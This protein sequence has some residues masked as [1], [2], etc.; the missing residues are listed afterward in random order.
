M[1]APAWVSAT[2]QSSGTATTAP[3]VTLPTTAANDVLILVR[4]NGGGTAL[5]APGGTYNG[6]AWASIDSGTW[7]T[8]AG[9]CMWSRCTGNHS[10]QTVTA[11]TVDSGS[12][13]VI[14]VSGCITTGTPLDVNKSGATVAAGA[15]GTLV[16]FNTTAVDTLVCLTVAVDDN[17]ALTNFTKNAVAMGNLSTSASSG[18]ADSGNGWAGSAQASPGATGD[19]A[20]SINAGTNEG[21][22]ASGFALLSVRSVLLDAGTAVSST[23]VALTA[24][25]ITALNAGT[26]VSSTTV[27]LTADAQITAEATGVSSA[28][29]DVTIPAPPVADLGTIAATGVSGGSAAVSAETQV[30]LVAATGVSGGSCALTAPALITGA[31]SAAGVSSAS[32]GLTAAAQLSFSATAVSA[33]TANATAETQVALNASTAVSAGTCNVTATGAA[34][35][36]LDAATASSAATS[37]V[38]AETRVAL[39]TSTAVSA[40]TVGVSAETRV[41]LS[42]ATAVSVGTA[43]VRTPGPAIVVPDA[44][45]AVSGALCLVTAPQDVALAEATG[46]SSSTL[47]VSAVSWISLEATAVSAGS[48]TVR[49]P[50]GVEIPF[51]PASAVTSASTNVLLW[52][53]PGT[54]TSTI[55]LV[56]SLSSTCTVLATV[57]G[58]DAAANTVEVVEG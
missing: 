57:T 47:Q 18:G 3:S 49:I 34:D 21:K 50:A 41:A 27:G 20:F 16:G 37:A 29:A 38:T 17:Q 43:D 51:D 44:S 31:V 54:V 13:L 22:R 33:G 46:V 6:S 14:R 10:G 30:A 23:T 15:N 7:T 39:S 19:F 55:R 58:T 48:A 36:A 45:T 4:I 52:A 2:A 1:A 24:D 35:V 5:A 8:G 42:A 26:A 56:N 28:T 40:G 25:A 9:G 11:V 53:P 32:F 12:L